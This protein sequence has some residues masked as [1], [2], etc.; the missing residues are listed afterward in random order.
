MMN[1]A[2]GQDFSEFMKEQDLNEEAQELATKK[3]LAAQLQ[4]ERENKRRNDY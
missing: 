3:V 1:E 4:A 2:L